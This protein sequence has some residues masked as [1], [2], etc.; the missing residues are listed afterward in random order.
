MR[1]RPDTKV[2]DRCLIDVDQKV[3]AIQETYPDVGTREHDVVASQLCYVNDLCD[4][5]QVGVNIDFDFHDK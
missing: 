1:H 5:G 2:S 4:A 3:F